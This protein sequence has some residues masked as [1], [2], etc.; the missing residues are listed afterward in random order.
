MEFPRDDWTE[1]LERVPL[2]YVFVFYFY[3]IVPSIDMAQRWNEA[4]FGARNNIEIRMKNIV[5]GW[6]LW[7]IYF[8]YVDW[9]L[10][11]FFNIPRTNGMRGTKGNWDVYLRRKSAFLRESNDKSDLDAY[12]FFIQ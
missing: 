8:G 12:K 10:F 11:E 1:Q 3:S 7:K 5:N 4:I 6:F 9:L 2:L